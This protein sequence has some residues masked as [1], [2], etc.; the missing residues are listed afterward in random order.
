[1]HSLDSVPYRTV[2]VHAKFDKLFLFFFL[3]KK[4]TYV[5]TVQ[6]WYSTVQYS[7]VNITKNDKKMIFGFPISFLQKKKEWHRK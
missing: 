6:Y 3:K 7:S 2:R 5:H 4:L 1:M